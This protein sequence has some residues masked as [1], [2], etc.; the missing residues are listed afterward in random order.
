MTDV[1]GDHLAWETLND[2]ADGRLDGVSRGA[3][4]A[5]LERCAECR[6]ALGELRCLLAAASDAPEWVDP[7]VG[8]WTAIESSIVARG[9]RSRRVAAR[10]P[11]AMDA[12]DAHARRA[13]ASRAPAYGRAWLAAAALALVVASS[14][15]TALV[16]S[17][18]LGSRG[19]VTIAARAAGAAGGQ[20]GG[21]AAQIL[22]ASLAAAESGYLTDVGELQRLFD[23]QRSVLS[24]STLA[25]VEHS[26]A[27]IDAAI[28]EARSALLADPSNG[29]LARL[30]DSTY[31]QKVELL[32]RAAELPQRS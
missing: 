16:M 12:N 27:T 5:H 25:V 7:P 11:Y 21:S 19:E 8:L 1:S 18:G 28:D 24:P 10:G 13:S 4:A 3:A 29:E 23:R 17:A 15:V 22:P 2:Y 6:D 20:S 9:A 14:G 31:R 32:R 30:L 26:L